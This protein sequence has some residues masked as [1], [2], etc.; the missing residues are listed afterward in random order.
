MRP[1]VHLNIVYIGLPGKI[2]LLSGFLPQPRPDNKPVSTQ[3]VYTLS[4]I[5]TSIVA[6]YSKYKYNY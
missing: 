4:I 6:K 1:E 5:K 3:L 2:L